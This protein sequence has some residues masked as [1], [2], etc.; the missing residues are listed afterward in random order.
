MI[1]VADDRSQSY[2]VLVMMHTQNIAR[3]EPVKGL[4]I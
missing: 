2:Q 3:L 1:E 4:V